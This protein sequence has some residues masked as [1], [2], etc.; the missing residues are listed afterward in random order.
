MLQSKLDMATLTEVSSITRKIIKFG[1]ISLII[2]A[3]IPSAIA[4]AKKIYLTLNPPPPPPPTIRYG[5]LPKLIWPEAPNYATPE[6]KL[7]TISGGFPGLPNMARVYAV[8]INKSR[9]LTLDRMSTRAKSVELTDDPVQ[10]DDRTYRFINPKEPIE[11]V[12]DVIS[13]SFSYKLDWTRDK[14]S[15]QSFDIPIGD[16]AIKDARRFLEKLGSLPEDL[17]SGRA[18]VV[19]LIATGS[20]MVPAVSAYE[21]NFTRVD[22]YRADKDELKYVTVGGN[23]SPVNVILSGQQGDK[24]IVQANYTYS[25]VLDNDFATYPLITPSDAWNKLLAGEGFIA[26]RTPEN[27]IIVRRITLAYFE[28]NEPQKFL[29]PV[30]LFEGD[31]GFMAYVP[32]ISPEYI[33][34]SGATLDF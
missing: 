16:A 25:Q 20:A 8:G 7:E 21:A 33:D 18:D 19:Y 9:L 4:L 2:M 10:L 3:L 32:A 30:Y 15:S 12:F 26:K 27:T 31:Q 17:N 6:Y 13:G 5:K 24:R 28:S 22:L 14:I 1:T 23:S 11:M 29:Q 34:N